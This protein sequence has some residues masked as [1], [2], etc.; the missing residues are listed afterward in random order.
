M[1]PKVLGRA[2]LSD[3]VAMGPNEAGPPWGAAL[4]GCAVLWVWLGVGRAGSFFSTVPSHSATHV[5]GAIS[6]ECRSLKR[7]SNSQC[8]WLRNARK[9]GAVQYGSIGASGAEQLR[10]PALRL[11][12]GAAPNAARLWGT[13]ALGF[14]QRGPAPA[15]WGVRRTPARG[16]ARPP[17]RF[18]NSSGK[19]H[20]AGK[21]LDN[22]QFLPP[23]PLHGKPCCMEA[24]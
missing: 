15:F 22:A 9:Q 10:R 19:G 8:W 6:V 21:V 1:A 11:Q 2:W 20:R 16:A 12:S 7:A 23:K 5:C 17:C 24:L 4:L 14:A 3:R 18:P 13:G